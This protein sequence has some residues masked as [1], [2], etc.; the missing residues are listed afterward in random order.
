[1]SQFKSIKFFGDLELSMNFQHAQR[2]AKI[3]KAP[4]SDVH[5]TTLRVGSRARYVNYV[6][7]RL[8][9]VI[10]EKQIGSD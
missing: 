2:K 8:I 9:N 3:Y 7:S 4:L 1:M 5:F 6:S 10:S